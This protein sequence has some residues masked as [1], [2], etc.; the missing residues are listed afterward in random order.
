MAAEAVAP[1]LEDVCEHPRVIKIDRLVQPTLS[2][3]LDIEVE[4][5]PP[6]EQFG[7]VLL[8][9]QAAMR[10]CGMLVAEIGLSV[11]GFCLFSRTAGSGLI[12][13]LA[14]SSA[15]RR[16]GVGSTLLSHGIA[17]LEQPTRRGAGAS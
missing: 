8:Q 11:A 12:S 4:A 14:V 15:F 1:P 10:T 13:K 17:E 2:Q 7:S 16:R 9:Q 3:V 5:F 6:C